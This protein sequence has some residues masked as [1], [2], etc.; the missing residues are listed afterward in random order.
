[1][2]LELLGSALRLAAHRGLTTAGPDVGERRA[3]FAV[4]LDEA[5]RRVRAIAE[6]T[7]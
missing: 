6:P 2:S 7:W 3:A 5:V 1:V 4:E